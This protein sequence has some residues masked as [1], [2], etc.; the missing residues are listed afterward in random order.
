MPGGDTAS[1]GGLLTRPERCS[2]FVGWQG[3]VVSHPH[4]HIVAGAAACSR[5]SV[6]AQGG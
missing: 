3:L 2:R 6:V 1:A 5:L 4:L